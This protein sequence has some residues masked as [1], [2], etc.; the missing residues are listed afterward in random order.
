M[1]IVDPAA[2]PWAFVAVR[3]QRL[4]VVRVRVGFVPF[5][6]TTVHF[7]R[8]NRV[9]LDLERQRCRQCHAGPR[10]PNE[11]TPLITTNAWTHGQRPAKVVGIL[12]DLTGSVRASPALRRKTQATRELVTDSVPIATPQPW[13]NDEQVRSHVGRIRRVPAFVGAAIIVGGATGIVGTGTASAGPATVISVCTLANFE[14]A[15]AAGGTVTFA[16]NCSLTLT[17]TVKVPS[18]LN[19]TINGGGF[20]VSLSGDTSV[21]LFSVKGGTLAITGITLGQGTSRGATGKDGMAGASGTT[22][23]NGANG[24][25]SKAG[26]AGKPGGA[27][28]AGEAGEAGKAGKGGAIYI[29]SGT[30]TLTSVTMSGDEAI[31]GGGGTG[32]MGGIGGMGG[33]GGNGG[34][35][36]NGGAG[37][38]GAPGGPVARAGPAGRPWEAP[39]TTP[40]PSR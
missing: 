2:G 27:G 34:T 17:N 38:N 29:K 13:G 10:S 24:T 5:T 9:R 6:P 22:G 16:T 3:I 37:G 35:G 21:Q 39:S 33:L 40:E 28:G 26:G 30:V 4:E 31:G 12:D 11:S 7:G 8:P 32:G 23:A 14:A 36:A 19:L 15:V 18:S 20:T 25:G 1:P